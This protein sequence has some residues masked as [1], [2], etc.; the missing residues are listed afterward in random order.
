MYSR[1]YFFSIL[2][3]LFV[4]YSRPYNLKCAKNSAKN[5]LLYLAAAASTYDYYIIIEYQFP[6][7]KYKYIHRCPFFAV[8]FFGYSSSLVISIDDYEKKYSIYVNFFLYSNFEKQMEDQLHKCILVFK[9][10]FYSVLLEVTFLFF[11]FF[12]PS[13]KFPYILH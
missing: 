11:F 4:L 8:W 6:S 13:M 9:H 5:K 3:P 2:S 1:G 10:E 12:L 7:R